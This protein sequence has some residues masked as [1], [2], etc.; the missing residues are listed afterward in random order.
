MTHPATP[1]PSPGRGDPTKSD[2][3]ETAGMRSDLAGS[4]PE[5]S[6]V[7]P[8]PAG[9]AQT[10]GDPADDAPGDARGT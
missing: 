2:D 5:G 10:D 6:T 4:A 1:R 7:S 8:A 9:E 3:H